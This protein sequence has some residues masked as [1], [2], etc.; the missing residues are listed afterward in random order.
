MAS[1]WLILLLFGKL[2]DVSSKTL[3]SMNQERSLSHICCRRCRCHLQTIR[4]SCNKGVSEF[5]AAPRGLNKGILRPP[6]REYIYIY[7]YKIKNM[8]DVTCF[9]RS[10]NRWNRFILAISL[11][12]D[13]LVIFIGSKR[14]S[15]AKSELIR[16]LFRSFTDK[17]TFSIFSI[18]TSILTSISISILISILI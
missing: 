13:G 1:F 2:T 12:S 6:K 9:D 18:L 10:K 8:I 5:L 15:H 4:S 16:M 14:C 3:T 11:I 7:T 17:H